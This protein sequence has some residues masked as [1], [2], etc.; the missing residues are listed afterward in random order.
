MNS[1]CMPVNNLGR[2]HAYNTIADCNKADL[3]QSEAMEPARL[4]QLNQQQKQNFYD[5]VQHRLPIHLQNAF[6]VGSRM[7]H[8]RDLPSEIVNY[9]ELKSHPFEEQFAV[10]MEIYIQQYRQQLKF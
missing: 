7:V 2:Q 9:R 5:F 1:G 10:N 8:T 3:C 4:D 6:T